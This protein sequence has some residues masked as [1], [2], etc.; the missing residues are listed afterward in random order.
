MKKYKIVF[1]IASGLI[2]LFEGVLVA[3]TW[4]SPM[5]IEGITHLGYPAYFGGL[6]ALFKV[7]GSIL[8]VLPVSKVT[9]RVKEWVYAGFGFDFTFAFLSIAIVDG[10]GAGSILPIVCIALLIAS[11]VSYHKLNPEA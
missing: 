10:I 9:P 6:L 2:F 3:F 8:L 11:Y 5:A 7:C 1:W 4:N